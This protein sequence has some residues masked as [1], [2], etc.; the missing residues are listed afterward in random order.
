MPRWRVGLQPPVDQLGV[1]KGRLGEAKH[2][3]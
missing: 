3:Q 1:G 2:Q